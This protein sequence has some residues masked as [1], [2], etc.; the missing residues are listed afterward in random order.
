MERS[1]HIYT[2][3]ELIEMEQVLTELLTHIYN[4][5]PGPRPMCI[6]YCSIIKKNIGI[7]R[8]EGWSDRE[9]LS[10]FIRDDWRCAMALHCGLPDYYIADSD[11]D[12]QCRLNEPIKRCITTLTTLIEKH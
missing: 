4:H 1:F 10:G 7:C 12:T 11:F 3:E 9:V 2:S 8:E 5:D 6:R